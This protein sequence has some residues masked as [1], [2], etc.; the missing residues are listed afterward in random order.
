[1]I[2]IDSRSATPPYEQLR[3]QFAEEVRSGSLAAGTRIPTVRKLAEDLGLAPNTVA[4]AYRELD[5]DGYII[6]QRGR[7]TFPA[8]HREASAADKRPVLRT[9][10]DKAVAEAAG[11]GIAA[12]EVVRFFREV[13]P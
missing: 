11:H 5:Q 2:Q 1:V 13:K 4:R 9:I 8:P 10:Y 3:V 12:V 6:S 7:G